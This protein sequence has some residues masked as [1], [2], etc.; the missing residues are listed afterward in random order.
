M[1]CWR[2]SFKKYRIIIIIT[3][4]GIILNFN[5]KYSKAEKQRS[6]DYLH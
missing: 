6:D 4:L 1:V 2:S 5:D 3:Y